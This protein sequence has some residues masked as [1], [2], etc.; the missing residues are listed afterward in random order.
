[1]PLEA[2]SSQFI[3]FDPNLFAGPTV[4]RVILAEAYR[5]ILAADGNPVVI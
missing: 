1:L 4:L 3:G 5:R 2:N